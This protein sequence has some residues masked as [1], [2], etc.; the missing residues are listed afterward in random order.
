MSYVMNGKYK[1]KKVKNNIGNVVYIQPN[2]FGD[3]IRLDK[4]T[5]AKYEV[6]TED[7]VKSGSSAILRGAVGVALL[8]GVGVLAGL[9]AKNKSTHIVAVEWKSGE[10]SL[11]SLKQYE[12]AVLVKNMF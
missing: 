2:I 6:I 5:L 9:S 8:G 12:Y 3:W 1:D 11:L 7:T 10:K 4:N